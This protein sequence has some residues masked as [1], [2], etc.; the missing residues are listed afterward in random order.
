MR[1]RA[2]R[3]QRLDWQAQDAHLGH[4]PGRCRVCW[5]RCRNKTPKTRPVCLD[6]Q[7][8]LAGHPDVAVRRWLAAVPGLDPSTVAR[9]MADGDPQTAQA[10]ARL[11][12]LDWE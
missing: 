2:W 6:C 4:R 1:C 10:A 7:Q 5:G 11:C 3:P 8:L 12:D 9:L